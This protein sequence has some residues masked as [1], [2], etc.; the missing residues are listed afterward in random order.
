[1]VEDQAGIVEDARVRLDLI[2]G[3]VEHLIGEQATPGVHPLQLQHLPARR[4]VRV[5][6][7][8]L[9]DRVGVPEPADGVQARPQREA[10]LLLAQR[11]PVQLGQLHHHLQADPLGA[12]QHE[13]PHLQPE[14]GVFHLLGQIGHHPQRHQVE[15]LAR[16]LDAAGAAEQLARHLERHPHAGQ[17]AQRV[18]P[19]DPLRV[20]HRQRRRQL[21]GQVVMVG[22]DHVH[23]PAGGVLHRFGRIHA[24]VAGEHQR[25][26]LIQE[27]AQRLHADAVR[28]GSADRDVERRLRAQTAQRLH[29]QRGGGLA[30]DVEVSPHA[31]PLA[32]TERPFDAVGGARHVR[33]VVGRRRPVVAGV[34][35]RPGALRRVEAAPH[36]GLRQHR[37]PAD[38]VPQ[39]GRHVDRGRLLPAR[40]DPAGRH[41][42]DTSPTSA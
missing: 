8:Q 2:A 13:Q 31:D 36:Q 23:A 3:G 26:A 7:H 22:D 35:E 28:L 39:R 11:L 4:L 10:D 32:V 6:R 21:L 16:L 34:Q 29:Q 41:Q 17:R 9:D 24:G 27:L 15:Q 40:G 33:Q 37:R 14:P 38:G 20:D 18:G 42:N 30:V 19:I 25:D 1:M 12:P 5:G